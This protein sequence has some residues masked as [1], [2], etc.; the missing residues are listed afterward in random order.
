MYKT[1]RRKNNIDG[2]MKRRRWLMIGNG[3]ELYS[4]V[5]EDM[6]ERTRS[7]EDLDITKYISQKMKDAGATSYKELKDKMKIEK[8]GCIY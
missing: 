1:S 2:T 3:D 5:I 4:L 7:R 6:I 8:S